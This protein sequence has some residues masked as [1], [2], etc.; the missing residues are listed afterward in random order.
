M[1]ADLIELHHLICVNAQDFDSYLAVF[2]IT[3]P[4]FREHY[5][6]PRNFR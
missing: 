3:L 1:D 5:G 2:K 4:Y 6:K